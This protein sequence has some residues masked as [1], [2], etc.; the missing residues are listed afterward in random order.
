[1]LG[2]FLK[3]SPKHPPGP[4]KQ[5]PFPI[6]RDLPPTLADIGISYKESAN[7]QELAEIQKEDPD[8]F[9]EVRENKTSFTKAK[10]ARRRAQAKAKIAETPTEKS[11]WLFG[12]RR[13]LSGDAV[14]C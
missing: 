2:D 3:D 13:G 10:R 7:A 5:D 1:M 12:F 4:D 8:T 6:E 9:A 14:N 11:R